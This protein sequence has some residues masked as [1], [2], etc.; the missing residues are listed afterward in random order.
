MAEESRTSHTS[1]I[2]FIVH[3]LLSFNLKYNTTFPLNARF[4]R[5]REISESSLTISVFLRENIL[6]CNSILTS[7]FRKEFMWLMSWCT[8]MYGLLS[9]N[10]LNI[11]IINNYQCKQWLNWF[12]FILFSYSLCSVLCYIKRNTQYSTQKSWWIVYNWHIN[13]C[14]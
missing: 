7:S 4:T 8:P 11:W 10:Y 5:V 3:T 6:F 1:V 12:L 2:N 14:N 13:T 9:I